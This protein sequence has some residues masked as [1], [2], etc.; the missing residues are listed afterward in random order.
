MVWRML[1]VIVLAFLVACA[2]P[3]PEGEDPE[4][5]EVA[6]AE[7][8]DVEE[9]DEVLETPP[10]GALPLSSILVTVEAMVDAPI[11]EVEFEDGVWE[12][13]CV[14]DGEEQEFHVDPMTGEVLPSME[15]EEEEGDGERG[16]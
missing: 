15:E 6:V 10:E 8:V 16:E 11:V 13:E 2:G 7:T 12:I 5:T 9:D 14:T 3:A 4:P 1:S